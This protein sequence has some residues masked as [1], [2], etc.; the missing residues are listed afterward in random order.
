MERTSITS[1]VNYTPQDL[2]CMYVILN[3]V[4]SLE[5][6]GWVHVSFARC[7]Y[8]L[9][10]KGKTRGIA[11]YSNSSEMHALFYRPICSVVAAQKIISREGR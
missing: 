11:E 10:C 5:L 4:Y 6:C 3:I 9:S 7:F 1:K 2:Y 8:R